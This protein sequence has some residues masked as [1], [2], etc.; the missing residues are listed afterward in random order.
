M[1]IVCAP[2]RSAAT[3][4]MVH[5]AGP[6][7]SFR[8]TLGVA[9]KLTSPAPFFLHAHP[10]SYCISKLLWQS[11]E[12]ALWRES[13]AYVRDLAT[14]LD[15]DPVAL[16]KAV[17]PA[18]DQIK[19]SLL[20]NSDEDMLCKAAIP[21]AAGNFAARCRKP[22]VQLADSAHS[23]FC[24]MH[25]HAQPA[26]QTRLDC[27]IPIPKEV[28]RLVL[29]DACD[30]D[31]KDVPTLWVDSAGTVYDSTLNV[32]GCYDQTTG[33]LEFFEVEGSE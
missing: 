2:R 21:L 27:G 25:Q 28:E 1:G 7:T 6:H 15:V 4:K 16:E 20:D 31:G 11:L 19:V 8:G 23:R 17:L 29:T 22:V 33:E 30:L 9:A 14:I 13:R 10:M 24:Y 12:S 3:C 32:R 18:R 5:A 26:I